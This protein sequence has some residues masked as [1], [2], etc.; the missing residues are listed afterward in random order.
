VLKNTF[1]DYFVMRTVEA[2]KLGRFIGT[3]EDIKFWYRIR[4]NSRYFFQNGRFKIF[5]ASTLK[6][7]CSC[8]TVPIFEFMVNNTHAYILV[9]V[10]IRNSVGKGTKMFR[11]AH[12]CQY[13]GAQ[14]LFRVYLNNYNKYRLRT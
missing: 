1:V 7:H 14:V 13:W 9:S 10:D 2:I 4:K 3:Y 12:K 11:G 5:A 8:H 6:R